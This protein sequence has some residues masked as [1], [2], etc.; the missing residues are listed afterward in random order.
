[1][2]PMYITA[3]IRVEV[4][5]ANKLNIEVNARLTELRCN[6]DKL[7]AKLTFTQVK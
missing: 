1:M 5:Q 2:S 7:L 3:V 4:F 6:V